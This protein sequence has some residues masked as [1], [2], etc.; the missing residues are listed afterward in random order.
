[1]V[2]C[3]GA[4]AVRGGGQAQL[5]RPHSCFSAGDR[6]VDASMCRVVAVGGY[7]RP[8]VRLPAPAGGHPGQGVKPA[9]KLRTSSVFSRQTGVEAVCKHSTSSCCS[10]LT[11]LL[12]GEA[13]RRAGAESTRPPAPQASNVAEE[14]VGR[15]LFE[16]HLQGACGHGRGRWRPATMGGAKLRRWQEGWGRPSRRRDWLWIQGRGWRL[17]LEAKEMRVWRF[18]GARV[19]ELV[20]P[21]GG[22]AGR[23][24]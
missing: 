10:G 19:S 12:G 3:S 24:C 2:V 23:G 7:A 11:A 9:S 21:G 4:R 20:V 17:V 13:R 5:R 18:R 8:M 22:Q 15:G 16:A 14:V 6:C 1:M